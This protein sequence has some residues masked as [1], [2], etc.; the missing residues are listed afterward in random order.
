MFMGRVLRQ[1]L[2]VWCLLS[3]AGCNGSDPPADYVQATPSVAAATAIV[4]GASQ[5]VTVTFVSSDGRPISDLSVSGVASL[6]AGW[7]GPGTFGCATVT[8]GSG[9]VLNLA[10]AP[11]AA[12][13][14]TL[15]LSYSYT[16]VDGVSHT[17]SL[18]IPYSS[19]SNDNVEATAAPTGQIT[20]A[21]N[22]GSQ[23]VTLTFTTDDGQAATGLTLT[24]SLS[25]LPAGWSSPATAL[26]CAT[27]STG[28]G[29]QLA[30]TFAPLT[31]G[32]GTLALSYTYT[33]NAGEAKSGSVSIPY[34]ATTDDSVVGTA[35][36]SGQV[37][38]TAGGTG[39][40]VSITFATDDG[41]PATDL[42][43]TGGLG[44][45]PDGWSGPGSFSCGTVSAGTACQL[46]L[47]YAP[48]YT[49]AGGTLT[50]NYSYDNDEGNAKTG[51]IDIPYLAT[52]AHL[53][54]TNL[55][56]QLD[57]CNIG[58]GGVLSTCAQTPASG[59]PTYPSGIAFNGNTAYVADF[60]HAAI[61]V[62]A[63]GADG[64]LSSCTA[65]S[66]F[67]ANWQPWA[68]AVA[69]AGNGTSYLY[70]TDAN[71]LY[72]SVQQ[73][74]LAADGSIAGC[75][76]TASGI[77]YGTGIAIGGGYAY[78]GTFNGSTFIVDACNYNS[79]GS[80]S[81]C[82]VTGSGFD[83]PSFITIN[84][85]YVYVVN[86]GAGTVSVCTVGANGALS[87]C[88][89][90][91]LPG[92]TYDANSVAFHGSQAYV[93][94]NNGNLWLCAVDGGTGALTSCEQG[95]GSNSFSTSQQLAIH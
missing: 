2:P 78:I 10:Y 23:A 63:V 45:L 30:L 56:T 86:E 77:V 72:G 25:S 15:S 38:A 81:G 49:G 71:S 37:T 42:D 19:T 76:Q 83:D 67:P 66:S 43:I 92:G 88:P 5:T 51:T 58:A 35:A 40:S 14:G 70:A 26:T 48:Q 62:C 61:D 95:K 75:A 44:S 28:N 24:S 7:S 69:T 89:T 6:P 11:T 85:G 22:S 29:C 80:I 55:W 90:S 1:T 8:T 39:T 84:S 60:D 41:N 4:G 32:S 47:A 91:A 9:C 33:D 93:D 74:Q 64:S 20:A 31:A 12:A 82:A 59:G 13:S 36:P 94:D 73:C 79:D 52:G 65:Y 16:S 50:L 57:E 34:A 18:T 68:L 54:V 17:S 87:S 21:V 53:Y 46:S 3:L 27:V